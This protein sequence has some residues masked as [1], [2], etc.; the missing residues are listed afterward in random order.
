MLLIQDTNFYFHNYYPTNWFYIFLLITENKHGRGNFTGV[1]SGGFGFQDDENYLVKKDRGMILFFFLFI[2]TAYSQ[3]ASLQMVELSV[4]HLQRSTLLFHMI[5]L[6]ITHLIRII[7][8][9]NTSEINANHFTHLR[10]MLSFQIMNVAVFYY[11]IK[12]LVRWF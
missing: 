11:G 1:L 9:Y 5:E 12:N 10:S 2:F 8:L 3:G 7:E 4:A 6:S